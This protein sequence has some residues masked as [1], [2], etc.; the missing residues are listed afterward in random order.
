M[1]SAAFSKELLYRNDFSVRQSAVA[2]PQGA[3]REVPYFPGAFVNDNFSNPFSGTVYQDGWI[4]GKNSCN[5][6][7]LIVDDNGNQEAVICNSSGDNRH[8]VL[9]HRL[10][11]TLTSGLVTAQ[12]D[13]RAPTDWYGYTRSIRFAL[14]DEAFFSPETDSEGGSEYLK[15]IT[16]YAGVTHDDSDKYHFYRLNQALEPGAAKGH[17]Y[18]LVVSL[19]L[20]ARTWSCAYY[21]LGT[22]HPDLETET[23]ETPVYTQANIPMPY[24]VVTSV[25]ALGITCYCPHGGLDASTLSQAAQFDN[26]RVAHNGVECYRNDFTV[27]RSRVLDGTLTGEYQRNALVTNTVNGEVYSGNRIL[28][29]NQNAG[30]TTAQPIGIDGWR[31]LNR[32][33][34][35]SAIVYP[36]SNDNRLMFDTDNQF[37]A[38]AHP[39]G[40]AV[41]TGILRF[42]AEALVPSNW[43]N[44]SVLYIKLGDDAHYGGNNSVYNSK[45]YAQ[46]GFREG[47][48][49]YY[50][51]ANRVDE[52]VTIEKGSWYRFVVTVDLDAKRYSFT[53]EKVSNGERV[54]ETA[55]LMNADGVDE[56][57][58]FSLWAYYARVMYD[59]IKVFYKANASS[60]ERPLY[61]NTFSSRTYYHQN[62]REGAL[63]GRLASSPV[64]QDGWKRV[65]TGAAKIVVRKDGDNQAVSFDNGK[66]AS[67][68][69]V[70]D[71]G[72]NVK[73]GHLVTQIDVKPPRTWQGDQRG[74]YFWLGGD[75]FAE[76]NC[77][78]TLNEGNER[79]SKWGA[80]L[81][82]FSDRTGTANGV[83]LY[84]NVSAC[85]SIGDGAGGYELKFAE[86]LAI[87]AT[88]WYRFVIKANLDSGV[89]D[90]ELYDMGTTHPTFATAMPQAPVAV[91]GSL[92]FVRDA[93]LLSGISSIGF[94]TMGVVANTMD[95]R[96]VMFWDNISVTSK[97]NGFV[98]IVQ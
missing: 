97:S 53:L 44:S 57:S 46:V 60:P 8:A 79:F 30:L 10:G 69:A 63:V 64:G 84:T 43:K 24:A 68:Y 22:D 6:P 72:K 3:W 81:V 11:T 92:P 78:T 94:S 49:I 80:L 89:S 28:V 19:D 91:F 20:D 9:K 18:R 29:A 98:I 88:R 17:W 96:D 51:G 42:E 61:E 34:P 90:V 40:S 36:S 32:D 27:R 39:L 50:N 23:P 71:L 4:R 85:V 70:N 62:L 66:N 75:R 47:K 76:G 41:R 21:D 59:N 7:A 82:G 86:D 15:R 37:G 58:C 25:S 74:S 48:L 14:G 5:C 33:G 52:S 38:A 73:T 65:D 1:V 45:R 31:R 54:F 87:D 35:V 2:V 67:G 55:N 83:G 93:R 56:I 12:C 26:I 95:T 13:F 16:L 77:N